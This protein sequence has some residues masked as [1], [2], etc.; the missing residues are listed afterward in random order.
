MNKSA[1]V[2]I[3]TSFFYGWIIVAIAGLM[4]FFSGP[5][6]TYAIST[7]IDYYIA[8]FDW[9]RSLISGLYSAAT[10]I[11]SGL[12]FLIGRYIDRFGQRIMAIFVAS[13]LSLACFWNSFVAGPIMLFAGFILLR[14]FGQGS[15]TLIPATLVSQWFIAYR[16]RALSL[17]QI[18]GIMS[19]AVIPPLNAWMLSLWGP[20]VVWRVWSF[21]LA[22]IFIPAAFFFIR[23]RPELVGL[24]PDNG[25]MLQKE[26]G[27]VE[28]EVNWTLK[29]AMSTRVFWF[30][31][32]C[33]IIP[34]MV[35][36]GLVF[37]MVSILG[38]R[39]ITVQVSSVVLGLMAIVAFPVTFVAGFLLERVK[40]HVVIALASI[41]QI[42]AMSVLF[43]VDSNWS[44]YLFGI[45]RG[46]VGGFEMIA[47]GIILPNYFGRLHIGSIKGFTT[48]F[49]V[50]GSALGPLPFGIAYDL[51]NGYREVLLV[52]LMFPVLGCIAAWYSPK[53]RKNGLILRKKK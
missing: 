44:A 22:S 38:E 36:T 5:G 39:G 35:N 29:E 10:L 17:M 16:G 26:G 1:P 33:L 41:G 7:F 15:M 49:N 21:L 12:L 20:S 40:V 32:V 23:N 27:S 25:V 52:M 48:T 34:S 31:I 50:I 18:G 4:L 24:H 19:S 14:L 28:E 43:F 42:I 30:I 6:Q 37:H 11:A 8:Q 45:I 46:I 53:P 3:K 51:F 2:P 47:L 13:M 9:S